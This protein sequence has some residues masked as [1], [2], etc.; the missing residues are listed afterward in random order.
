MSARARLALS[1]CLAACAPAPP[2]PQPL[3]RGDLDTFRA[4]V[5]PV[6]DARCAD[7]SCHGRAE[8][9]LSLFS[10]G[11]R[12]R[13]PDV[14]FTRTPLDDD[15]L[16]AN[17]RVLAA[18]ALEP[19]LS[20]EPVDAC[21]VLRKPLAVSRGGASHEG[22]ELFGGTDDRDYQTLRDWLAALDLPE[23]P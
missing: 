7:P 14:T 21:L 10:P 3:P 2:G 6:L 5:Q 4:S 1:L 16:A 23:V 18:F 8:R 11:R 22:G 13:D 20:G 15:E 17:A 19:L 9:P 12:R